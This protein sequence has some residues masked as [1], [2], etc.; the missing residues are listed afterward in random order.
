MG[1]HRDPRRLVATALYEWCLGVQEL[2]EDTAD[3]GEPERRVVKDVH[4]KLAAKASALWERQTWDRSYG[5]KCRQ[6]KHLFE[7]WE[8]RTLWGWEQWWLCKDCVVGYI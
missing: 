3:W 1:H 8:G 7:W 4:G 6:C 5:Q 2:L